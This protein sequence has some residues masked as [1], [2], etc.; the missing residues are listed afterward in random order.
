MVHD[1]FTQNKLHGCAHAD[2]F[3]HQGDA[4]QRQTQAVCGFAAGLAVFRDA[5]AGALSGC[6]SV[7]CLERLEMAGQ[8]SPI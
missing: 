3:P 4:E 8:A 1:A 2:S 5:L 7:L 6:R